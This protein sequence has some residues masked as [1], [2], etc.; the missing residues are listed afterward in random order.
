MRRIVLALV[1]G[2]RRE[3]AHS[4]PV[5]GAQVL[6]VVQIWSWRGCREFSWAVNSGGTTGCTRCWPGGAESRSRQ[7]SRSEPGTARRR[8]YRRAAARGDQDEP[9][10]GAASRTGRAGRT[11]AEQGDQAERHVGQQLRAPPHRPGG[12]RRAGCRSACCGLQLFLGHHLAAGDSSVRSRART[13]HGG[14]LGAGTFGSIG[15][16]PRAASLPAAM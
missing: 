8:V 13:G 3:L 9:A 15:G 11:E 12:H 6:P 10:E 1:T 4:P 7:E 16:T 5:S 2:S 14:R